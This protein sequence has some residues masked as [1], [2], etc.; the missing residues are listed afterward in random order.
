MTVFLKSQ[1]FEQLL[2]NCLLHFYDYA[3]LQENT[4]VAYLVPE[5]TTAKRVQLFREHIENSIEKMS[6]PDNVLPQA[7]NSRLYNVLTLRYLEQEDIDEII[8]QLAISR[9]QYYR[10]LSRAIAS[11]ANILQEGTFQ[12]DE[13]S[14][15]VFT[16]QSEIASL[17]QH[18]NRH[19]SVNLNK[20]LDGVIK[21]NS[22]LAMNHDVTVHYE[23]FSDDVTVGIDRGLVRQLL[24]VLLSMLIGLAAKKGALKLGCTVAEDAVIFS[25]QIDYKQQHKIAAI[26]SLTDQQTISTLLNAVVGHLSIFKEKSDIIELSIPLRRSSILIIDDNP[27]VISLFRRLL[28]ALTYRLIIANDGQ[29][30][31]EVVKKQFVDLIILDIMLPEIDGF[32]ILQILKSN[33]STKDLP[34]VICSVLDSE[35]LAISLGANAFLSKPPTQAE[36]HNILSQWS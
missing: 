32:E 4:L 18:S 30:I 3:Y 36:L 29:G 34:V 8:D 26:K 23:F 11:L 25:F 16:V 19:I 21:A 28:D 20:L 27:D 31:L 17:R 22:I 13:S 33:P 2:Q 5:E 12:F 14:G 10:E 7:K 24:L 15:D 9:R 6:P 1:E 35:E